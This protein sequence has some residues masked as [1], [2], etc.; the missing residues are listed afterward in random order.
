MRIEMDSGEFISCEIWLRRNQSKHWQDTTLKPRL[1]FLT[2]ICEKMLHWWHTNVTAVKTK[3]WRLNSCWVIIIHSN[4]F[5]VIRNIVTAYA[6]GRS[7]TARCSATSA[8]NAHLHQAALLQLPRG[9]VCQRLPHRR[10]PQALP[11]VTHSS[12]CRSW[13]TD[14]AKFTF[15]WLTITIDQWNASDAER[16]SSRS[17]HPLAMYVHYFFIGR[18]RFRIETTVSFDFMQRDGS[19]V[20]DLRIQLSLVEVLGDVIW[21]WFNASSCRLFTVRTKSCMC[22]CLSWSARE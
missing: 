19:Q 9:E 5:H 1:G 18:E 20:I 4:A 6:D 15:R 22:E 10:P 2:L 16:R 7:A 13:N 11:S 14:A 3:L 12:R 21:L 8:S 17:G